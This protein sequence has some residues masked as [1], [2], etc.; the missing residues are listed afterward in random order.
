MKKISFIAIF[1]AFV[2]LITPVFALEYNTMSCT[3]TDEGK[4]FYDAGTLTAKMLGI[5][6]GEGQYVTDNAYV[7]EVISDTTAEFTVLLIT[8]QVVIGS[9]YTYE[10]FLGPIYV[11]IND[12]IYYGSGD[13]NNKIIFDMKYVGKDHSYQ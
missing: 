7:V 2:F 9:Q 11:T 10:T 3:E 6:L 1:I 13:T 8:K 4:N 5:Q 12:I